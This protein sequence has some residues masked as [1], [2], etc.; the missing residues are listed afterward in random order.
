MAFATILND[1]LRVKN[2]TFLKMP[3]ITNIHVVKASNLV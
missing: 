1:S 2:V 3:N